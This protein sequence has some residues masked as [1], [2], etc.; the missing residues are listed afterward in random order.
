[1]ADCICDPEIYS[2]LEPPPREGL[3]D[4]PQMVW[5]ARDLPSFVIMEEVE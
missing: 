1:M 3:I 5:T 2:L 4:L